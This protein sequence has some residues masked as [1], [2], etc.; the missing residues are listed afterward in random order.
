MKKKQRVIAIVGPTAV[1]KTA[2][3]IELAKA[4]N[5]EII[6]CDSMQIYRTMDIGT[7][8]PTR[9]EMSQVPHH[10]IDIKNP[11]EQFSCADYASVA[12]E[13]IEEII[14]RGK[15]PIFCGGT[16][17][18][19]DSVI[20]IPAFST[21]AK[22]DFYRAFLEKEALEKGKGYVHDLLK[23]V[24]I[25]SADA[26]HENNLKRVIRALE[27]YHCTGITKSEWD[28]RSKETESPYEATVFFLTC[29]DRDLLYSRIEKRVDLMLEE[30]L[31]DEARSLF[32]KG[33]LD[34]QYTASGAI[35]YKEFIP[36]LEGNASLESCVE[37]L[38]LST[39]HYA[40]RQ[41]TWFSRHD[42]YNT[43]YVD[44]Q[45]PIEVAKEILKGNMDTRKR[46]IKE[47]YESVQSKIR[48]L[49][50]EGRV[51][52]LA[53]TKMQNA[54]DI[55]YLISLGCFCIGENRVN[56]LLE[57]Y[58]QYDKSAE[59]HFIGTLQKNK[60][61]Y[62]IDK[63][64]LIH[65]VDSLSLL[66]EI[67]KRAEKIGRVVNVLIEVN[68]GREEAKGGIL[69]EDVAEFCQ[70]A[71]EYKSVC[72]RGLMTMA[73]KCQT[74]EEYLYYFGIVKQL[75]DEL[76]DKDAI[77]SMGMSDSYEYAIE[78]GATMVRVGSKIFG[79]RKY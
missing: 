10:L 70:R 3:A 47:N 30:G 9:D 54:E 25:E 38:K 6:S 57:K 35:G 79:E 41:L 14:S 36:Y 28:R 77:L 67:N 26:I 53:A 60:V 48:E 8:K 69:P 23:E 52:L 15:T 46:Q 74:K 2:M 59:L 13:K 72:V 40:K 24:D 27:I 18:Y 37:E 58:D 19:L 51:T 71:R 5:G 64:S 44:I 63:V 49:D 73:P 31:L 68:S 39:R 78:A 45:N 42:Y 43:I 7:A 21:S 32:E 75:F 50:K 34:K 61:K 11:D 12:K 20:E 55:N 29:K 65:S 1:G 22:D 62:I 76:F 33:Y 16:G 56:E 66:E 17:L 4:L